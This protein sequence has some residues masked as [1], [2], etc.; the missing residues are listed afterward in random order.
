MVNHD[1]KTG[2]IVFGYAVVIIAAA[3]ILFAN[4]MTKP[5]GHDEHMYC[6]AGALTAQGQMLWRD[7]SY[8]AQLPVHPLLL[9]SIYKITGTNYYLLTARLF[10]LACDIIMLVFIAGI[11]RYWFRQH[12]AKGFWVFTCVTVFILF[13]PFYLY[14]TGFGWN[15]DLTIVLI[16]GMLYFIIVAGENGKL[17]IWHFLLAGIFAGAAVFTRAT[18]LLPVGAVFALVFLF[19]RSRKK[20]LYGNAAFFVAGFLISALWPGYIILI[21]HQSF[22]ESV[23]TIPRLNAQY[24]A[25]TGMIFSKSGMTLA[26]VLTPAYLLLINVIIVFHAR[27]FSKRKIVKFDASH[28]FIPLAVTLAFILAIYIPPTIWHQYFGVVVPFLALSAAYAAARLMTV[29]KS[30]FALKL[31]AVLAIFTISFNLQPLSEVSLLL[32]RRNWTALNLH[33]T[34]SRICKTIGKG[35]VLTLAPLF[36]LEGG[37]DIYP[38]LAA[39]PF[40]YRI[41]DKLQK[42]GSGKSGYLDRVMTNHPPAGVVVGLEPAMLEKELIDIGEKCPRKQLFYDITVYICSP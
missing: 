1:R 34:S 21:N 33:K 23:F 12:T 15:H 35:R 10:S 28:G 14:A 6:A 9:G 13:N 31:L 5:L 24:L 2:L 7:F 8:V 30:T 20:V 38:E 32:N 11:F 18:T 4:G 22:I 3:V 29:P 41:A 42:D 16:M 19:N 39:G 17:R 25:E 36:A 27:L 40:I 26:V 37:C